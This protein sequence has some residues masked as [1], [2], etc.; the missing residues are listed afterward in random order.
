MDDQSVQSMTPIVAFFIPFGVVLQHD[1]RQGDQWFGS[2]IP[3][4]SKSLNQ[5]CLIYYQ[6]NLSILLLYVLPYQ[7][8]N[9]VFHQIDQI[10]LQTYLHIDFQRLRYHGD[11]PIFYST[12]TTAN[13]NIQ[14]ITLFFLWSYHRIRHC[15]VLAFWI[16]M[17]FG[18]L[19]Q[20]LW[21]ECIGLE[22]FQHL[23]ISWNHGISSREIVV[24]HKYIRYRRQS[25]CLASISYLKIHNWN[26]KAFTHLFVLVFSHF[27]IE[28]PKAAFWSVVPESQ[29]YAENCHTA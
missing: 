23:E 15:F 22:C 5:F 10:C 14:G 28:S 26:S 11:P 3:I 12:L 13:K 16:R 18:R 7:F 21:G 4:A 6:L 27:L 2:T 24:L 8:W 25:M 19:F 1:C 9:V 20:L 17:L 29:S